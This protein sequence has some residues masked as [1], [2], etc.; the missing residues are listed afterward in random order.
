[1]FK[2]VG[3]FE[4]QRAYSLEIKTKMKKKFG[5]KRRKMDKNLNRSINTTNLTASY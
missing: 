1:M 5:R 2:N 4:W 3:L